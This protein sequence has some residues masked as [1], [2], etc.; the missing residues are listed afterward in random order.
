[1]SLFRRKK[2]TVSAES[3]ASL[4]IV[5]NKFEHFKELLEF[6]NQILKLIS[7]LEEKKRDDSCSD[8]SVLN[9]HLSSLKKNVNE[10]IDRLLLISDKKYAILQEKANEIFNQ[11][12]QQ[13]PGDKKILPD[14]LT[15]PLRGL[16]ANRAWS[17][18]SKNAN[19]GELKMRL[20]L[21]VPGGF[22]ITAWAYKLFLDSNNLQK[23]ITDE[24]SEI[25][26]HK[27]EDLL[28]ASDSIQNLILNSPIPDE[29][30]ESIRDSSLDLQECKGAEL[31]SMRSSAIGEDTQFSFAGQYASYLNVKR[32]KLVDAYRQVIAGKFT[33]KAIYYLLSHS[34]KESELAMAV[35]CISM[36]N[37]K[38][39][40]V[41]Y[42]Q[43]PVDLSENCVVI[44][45][46]FG[47]GRL[48]VDGVITP[49]EI[50]VSRKDGQI[51]NVQVSHKPIQLTA[52][53][54]N[55]SIKKA[56]PEELAD[57][58]SLTEK[59]IAFLTEY[60]LMIEQHYQ[61]PQDIEWAIDKNNEIYILQSRP[62]KIITDLELKDIQTVSKNKSLLK[63]G[64]IVC[65]GIGYGRIFKLSSPED[66]DKV[67]QD[68]VLVTE[69]SFPGLIT[70]MEKVSALL[71]EVGGVASHTAT[72]AREY[73]L[74]T[75][76]NLPFFSELKV[77]QEVTVDA[78]H[79]CVYEGVASDIIQ[80]DQRK[81]EILQ[82]LPGKELYEYIFTMISPLNLIDPSADEFRAENCRTI[83]DI[84]RFTHQ[85]AMQEVFDSIAN[86]EIDEYRPIGLQT[87]IPLKVNILF[88]DSTYEKPKSKKGISENNIPFEPL[89][90]FWD[91]VRYEGWP[92][93]MQPSFERSV[94]AVEISKQSNSG[95]Q[96]FRETSYVILA[97]EYMMF[98]LYLG[99]HFTTIETICT[100]ELNK[101][102]IRFQHKGGGA[103]LER[104]I[105]RINL[106]ASILSKL[107]F[108]FSKKADFLDASLNYQSNENI[109]KKLYII[110]RMTMRTKQLDM[111]LTNEKITKWYANDITRRLGLT[112]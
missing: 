66:L 16:S 80:A 76:S 33:P 45:S 15:I 72:I 49:D 36:I 87:K 62:L 86:I 61:A 34:L 92:S 13:L 93:Q 19:L 95:S 58:L 100:Q 97:K 23:K 88:L 112:Q 21:P 9:S 85:K 60:A 18:G 63:G 24:I 30:A 3:S 75:I 102:Y 17:V 98:C 5:R 84:T 54:D 8:L 73:N 51:L 42:T 31:F 77:G 55:G 59:Q 71:V 6:N 96:G 26:L 90:Y 111:A 11:I 40:G 103:S 29:L 50:K 7:D 110:G 94:K 44:S 101:N 81:K 68:S 104:R 35:S 43:N 64:D 57:K 41:I 46:I 78:N 20:N 38:I 14:E 109:L 4:K 91:G 107:G 10:M 69:H 83:H 89:K 99:Y 105:N 32:E 56:V 74:P 28:R 1:M 39:S 106:I 48:L 47:L 70:A 52:D 108:E 37:S 12:K 22:A 82:N 2:F 25:D 53:P 27:Y 65:P 79:K 67:P